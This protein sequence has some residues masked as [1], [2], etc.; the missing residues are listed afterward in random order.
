[1]IRWYRYIP[2][3]GLLL[4]ICDGWNPVADL[5]PHHGEYACLCLWTGDAGQFRDEI[6]TPIMDRQYA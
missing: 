6:D 2:Y 1:M 4:A 3:D 5:G